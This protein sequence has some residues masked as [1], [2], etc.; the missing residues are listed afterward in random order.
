MNGKELETTSL[1]NFQQDLLYYIHCKKILKVKNKLENE[2]VTNV[3]LL[4]PKMP[5]YV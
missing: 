2:S 1:S 5:Q 3:W 4:S